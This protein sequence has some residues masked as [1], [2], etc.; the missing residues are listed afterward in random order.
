M[1]PYNS[2]GVVRDV[3]QDLFL[4]LTNRFEAVLL[5]LVD[6]MEFRDLY[7]FA[8]DAAITAVGNQVCAR[9]N[10]QTQGPPVKVSKRVGPKER[11]QFAAALKAL[12]ASKTP[13]RRK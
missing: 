5:P 9:V 13:R 1:K 11:K 10:G 12:E 7:D 4:E 3:A 6:R 8:R 2:N